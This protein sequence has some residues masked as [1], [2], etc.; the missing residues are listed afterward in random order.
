MLKRWKHDQ[1]VTGIA[2]VAG[3]SMPYAIRC[4]VNALAL[5]EAAQIRLAANKNHSKDDDTPTSS[6]AARPKK[7]SCTIVNAVVGCGFHG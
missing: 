3:A 5:A 7:V 4:L 2:G 1:S 6:P